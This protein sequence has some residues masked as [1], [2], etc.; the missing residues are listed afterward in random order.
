MSIV[1]IEFW[2]GYKQSKIEILSYQRLSAWKESLKRNN[3]RPKK[4]TKPY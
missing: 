1:K 4:G 3:G 2:A